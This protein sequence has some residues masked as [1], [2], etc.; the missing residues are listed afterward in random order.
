MFGDKFAPDPP[1]NTAFPPDSRSQMLRMNPAG[2]AAPGVQGRTT[3]SGLHPQG[4]RRRVGSNSRHLRG[5]QQTQ[6]TV[7]HLPSA[8]AAA[9]PTQQPRPPR[10]PLACREETPSKATSG[11]TAGSA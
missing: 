3:K 9:T 7:T 2:S 5:E 11:Q 6:A 1:I 8:G 4:Q 10:R